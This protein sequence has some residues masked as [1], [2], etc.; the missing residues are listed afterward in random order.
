MGSKEFDS[1][2]VGFQTTRFAAGFEFDTQKPGNLNCGHEFRDTATDEGVLDYEYPDDPQSK[3]IR[4]VSGV[5]GPSLAP[6]ERE[7][8]VEYLKTL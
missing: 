7:A 5:I 6:R 8:L 3:K 1:K 2:K 4:R